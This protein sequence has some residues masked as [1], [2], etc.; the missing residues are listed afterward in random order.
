VAAGR[1]DIFFFSIFIFI[2]TF[3]SAIKNDHHWFHTPSYCP[4]PEERRKRE[5]KKREDDDDDEDEEDDDQ[6]EDS[7]AFH[8][9]AFWRM[10]R[11]GRAA[12]SSGKM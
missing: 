2:I 12:C 3:F 11:L 8:W 9:W 4:F 7:A 5:E 10:R 1:V 6:E